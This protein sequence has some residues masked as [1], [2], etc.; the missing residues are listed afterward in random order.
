MKG[1]LD[2]TSRAPQ[3]FNSYAK[4]QTYSK[5]SIYVVCHILV[6]LRVSVFGNSYY[7]TFHRVRIQEMVVSCYTHLSRYAQFFYSCSNETEASSPR[8]FDL[9]SLAVPLPVEE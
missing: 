3:I 7:V 9:P 2:I 5:A 6:T 4:N 8:C 1:A